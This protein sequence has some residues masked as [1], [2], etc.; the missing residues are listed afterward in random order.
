MTDHVDSTS[1]VRFDVGEFINTLTLLKAGA[2]KLNTITPSSGLIFF[3]G[4]H[5]FTFNGNVYCGADSPFDVPKQVALN[6]IAIMKVLKGKK[7]YGMCT[8]ASDGSS[9]TFEV[10]GV[11]TL[12][13]AKITSDTS[14]GKLPNLPQAAKTKWKALPDPNVFRNALRIVESAYDKASVGTAMENLHM[15]KEFMECG[16]ATQVIRAVCELPIEGDLLV[17][18][19]ILSKIAASSNLTDIQISTDSSWFLLRDGTTYFAVPVSDAEYIADETMRMLFFPNDPDATILEFPDAEYNKELCGEIA[20]GI[21]FNEK[22]VEITLTGDKCSAEFCDVI[23]GNR[24]NTSIEGVKTNCKGS[25]KLTIVPA[26][27]MHILETSTG[28][29]NIHEHTV[30]IDTGAFAYVVTH[31]GLVG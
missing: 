10:E 16:T 18:G 7:G 20:R 3:D 31:F 9:A 23:N 22:D 25:V 21:A 5:M 26:V 27:L 4:K 2:D 24:F 19:G 13:T 6:Y 12:S 15:T 14:I 1:A 8:F 17:L 29:L 28:K 30:T 11:R